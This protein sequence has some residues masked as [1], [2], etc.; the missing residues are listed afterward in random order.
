MEYAPDFFMSETPTAQRSRA[1]WM[2]EK[3]GL[4]SEFLAKVLG[5]EVSVVQQ[6]RSKR[7]RLSPET[8]RLFRDLWGMVLHLYSL[9]G[10]NVERLHP[11]VHESG[12]WNRVASHPLLPPWVGSSMKDF[13]EQMGVEGIRKVEDWVMT[14]R[15]GNPYQTTAV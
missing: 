13:L 10:G 6:W 8:D 4:D 7:L 12:D 1:Q 14:F 9:C 5:I 15:F 2:E 11:M 3:L